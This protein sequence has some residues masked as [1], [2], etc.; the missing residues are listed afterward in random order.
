M[1][2]GAIVGSAFALTAFLAGIRLVGPGTASLL[3]TIEV[4]VGLGLAAA[5]L[6]DR[7]ATPQ[8]VGAFAVVGAIVLLQVRV[9]LPRP[10]RL[11][12]PV[13]ALV[14]GL[15]LDRDAPLRAPLHLRSALQ[16]LS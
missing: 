2:G 8:L 15:V 9:R 10:R 13:L 11:R 16:T 12:V 5:V 1:I 6:G 3:V 4:P 14:R 7:L